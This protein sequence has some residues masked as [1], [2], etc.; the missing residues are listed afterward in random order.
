VSFRRRSI[1]NQLSLQRI[2]FQGVDRL[3]LV[4]RIIHEVVGPLAFVVDAGG[5]DGWL[6]KYFVDYVNW[7]LLDGHDLEE[8][9]PAGD[10]TVLAEVLEHVVDLKK[11]LDNVQSEWV[12]V[13]LPQE[14]DFPLSV[15]H[16][17]RLDCKLLREFVDWELVGVW[18]WVMRPRFWRV[19]KFFG[20][21][22]YAEAEVSLWRR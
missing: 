17:R 18:S 14:R 20:V 1:E 21:S 4:A 22:H 11:V 12:L 3:E 15:D 9:I 8:G 2:K 6:A 5:G 19:R 16:T 7:D 13:T 10:V